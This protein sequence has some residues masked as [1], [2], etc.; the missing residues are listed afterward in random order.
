MKIVILGSILNLYYRYNL[1]MH[2]L[3]NT[4]LIFLFIICLSKLSL[5]GIDDPTTQNQESLT[6]NPF[7]INEANIK[8]GKKLWRK[9]GCYSCHGGQAEG[10]VGPNLQDDIWVYKPTDKMLFKTI[11]KGR[12]G[13]NMVGWEKELNNDEI[14]KIIIYIRSIYKG[15]PSKIIWE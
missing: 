8:D 9:T 15:D 1:T 3:F 4:T 11:A 12:R 7:Q 6:K 13:T 2:Y 14:W 5:A 10:G